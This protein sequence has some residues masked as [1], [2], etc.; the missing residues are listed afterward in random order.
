MTVIVIVDVDFRI[1]SQFF[2]A[3]FTKRNLGTRTVCQ[4]NVYGINIAVSRR[5][6]ILLTN[7]RTEDFIDCSVQL[8]YTVWFPTKQRVF[9]TCHFLGLFDFTFDESQSISILHIALEHFNHSL[10]LSFLVLVNSLLNS[11]CS[12]L[13]NNVLCHYL[14]RFINLI[15]FFNDCL[16]ILSCCS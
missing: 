8:I 16:T 12:S 14:I 3:N 2:K 5:T 7:G 10:F 6:V 11:S 15:Y 1:F 13:R 4:N 9:E